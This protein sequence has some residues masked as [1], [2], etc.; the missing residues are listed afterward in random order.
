MGD[1]TDVVSWTPGSAR[2]DL[3]NVRIMFVAAP[4]STGW[5]RLL[6]RGANAHVGPGLMGGVSGRTTQVRYGERE[7]ASAIDQVWS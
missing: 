5:D 2:E 6:R 3:P 4:R 7:T 1:G